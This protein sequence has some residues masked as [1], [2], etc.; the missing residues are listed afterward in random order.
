MFEQIKGRK[1]FFIRFLEPKENA[2]RTFRAPEAS[3]EHTPARPKSAPATPLRVTTPTVLPN[4]VSIAQLLRAGTLV[5]PWK[6]TT[7]QVQH[8]DIEK[9]KRVPACSINLQIEEEPFSSG[10]LRD[11]FKATCSDAGLSGGWVV[12]KIPAYL[13]KNHYRHFQIYS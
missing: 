10:A 6:T 11:A 8:F 2:D 12:K 13:S 1:I 9:S 3:F 7:L 5:K 4:S